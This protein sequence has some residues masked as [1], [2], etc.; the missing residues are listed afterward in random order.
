[1]KKAFEP[2]PPRFLYVLLRTFIRRDMQL[3]V[4][5]DFDEEYEEIA[6]KSG[7]RAANRWFR[8]HFFQSLPRII[9][10]TMIW[11]FD[12][13]KNYLTV[14]LRNM[15]RQKVFSLINIL[16][17]AIALM[18]CLWI[19]LFIQ[20][21]FSYDRFHENADSVYSVVQNDYHFNIKRRY[22]MVHTGPALKETFPD[23]EYAVRFSHAEVIVQQGDNYFQERC[24]FA[25][26]DFF[27]M[28]SFNLIQG[29]P[30]TVFDRES[31]VVLTTD[32][33]RKY[34]GNQDPMGKT[35]TVSIGEVRKDY[36]VTGLVEEVPSNTLLQFQMLMNIKELA[37][38]YGPEEITNRN[39]SQVY[40]FIQL[41]EGVSSK[42][43]EAGLPA[44]FEQ[45][46]GPLIED[47]KGRGSWNEEG[48][49]ISLWLQ[50][51]K[52]IY[53]YS[54]GIEGATESRIS[55]SYVLGGLGL[56][57]LFIACINFTNL[58]I[59]RASS[60]MVEI[61]MRKILGAHRKNLIRQFWSEALLTV[62]FAMLIGLAAGTALLPLFNRLAMKNIQE[63]DVFTLPNLVTFGVAVI[64]LSVL[65][66]LYPGMALSRILPQQIF[67]GNLKLGGKNILTRTLT[68]AQFSASIFLIIASLI[69]AKQVR[70]IFAKDLGYDREEVVV[71]KTFERR[72]YDINTQIFDIFE[73]ET[74]SLPYIK[75][76]SGCVF[77]L[78]SEVGSGKLTYNDKRL[79]FDF[80]SVHYNFCETMG[81]RFIAGGDY[82]RQASP[83]ID[84]I[85]VNEAFIKAFEI[86]NPIGTILF[87][88]PPPTQIIGV[89][90]DFHFW[91]LKQ[92]IQPTLIM[93]DKRTGP[94]NLL[95]RIDS[96]DISR[97]ISGLEKIW[98]KAQPNKPFDYRFEDAIF[99]QKY[100]E[101]KRWSGIVFFAS[102]F[103]VLISCMGL[104]GITTL[105]ISR[106]VKEVGI[107]RVLGAPILKICSLLSW[108]YLVLVSISNLIAWPLGYYF[109]RKWIEAYAYRTEIDLGIFLL[110]GFLSLAV[111]LI[112]IGFIVFRAASA[113]P[114]ES[115]RYE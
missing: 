110:A 27:M 52:D 7:I 94:R 80:T 105:A 32:L 70:Y 26:K 34:F 31:A 64:L 20:D 16:G 38:I 14:S 18:V 5:G 51:L 57:I 22:T 83:D 75:S 79:D 13:F 101:E 2:Q 48:P 99:Q 65:A 112:T 95:V 23:I 89:V 15:S 45:Y 54:Q 47:R 58:S 36:L 109:M 55:I 108:E 29:D 42:A 90:E 86:E 21:E 96:S 35:L 102:F 53:L 103:A 6:R 33:A 73:A 8:K 72:N 41:K 19:F 63:A 62:F 81:I 71:I 30:I 9:I 76:V 67:R 84:P 10:D 44:F 61:G 50:D 100:A 1:M 87:P 43:I 4:L 74:A 17:V 3:Y 66:G 24:D 114:V 12:M 68:I 91:N 37:K 39:W 115:L 85:I 82:S 104:V 49:T 60:R 78:S 106:R 28:F 111:A 88:K 11:R 113:N 40:T 93:L 56:L 107:R 25:D 92:A 46:F 77:P 98:K 97:A 59:G 69:V